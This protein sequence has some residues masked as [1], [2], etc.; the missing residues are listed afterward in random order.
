M[1]AGDTKIHV[2][3]GVNRKK[4]PRIRVTNY[5]YSNKNAKILSLELTIYKNRTQFCLIKCEPNSGEIT[6]TSVFSCLQE[7]A[8]EEK[9]EKIEWPANDVIFEMCDMHEFFKAGN[10][11]L[12][13]LHIYVT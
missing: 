9:I 4:T 3:I 6:Y 1:E 13:S 7:L 10:A 12:N 8:D 2:D 5:R 11:S